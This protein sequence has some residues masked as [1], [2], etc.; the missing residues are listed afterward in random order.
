LRLQGASLLAFLTGSAGPLTE[1]NVAMSFFIA[2]K[3]EIRK[4]ILRQQL[5]MQMGLKSSDLERVK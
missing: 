2:P 1:R 5:S 4:K 3:F